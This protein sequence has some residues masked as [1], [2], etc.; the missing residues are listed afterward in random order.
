M[1]YNIKFDHKASNLS[2]AIQ[3][4][5]DIN[6]VTDDFRELLK[7][8]NLQKTEILEQIL[9]KYDPQTPTDLIAIGVVL[10][11]LNG[12]EMVIGHV[13]DANIPPDLMKEMFESLL[14]KA[15]KP[16]IGNMSLDKES[17]K[18]VMNDDK[19]DF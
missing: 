17:F 1:K 13:K 9:N 3:V 16:N 18:E 11:G 12:T 15:F 7:E 10:G 4:S 2:D 6:K 19:N 14:N 5:L 8:N